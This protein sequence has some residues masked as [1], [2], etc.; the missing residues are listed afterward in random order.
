MRNQYGIISDYSF[1][2]FHQQHVSNWIQNK[3]KS[4][5]FGNVIPKRDHLQRMSQHSSTITVEIQKV[6]LFINVDLMFS[7]V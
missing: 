3:A 7:L 1:A 2:K 5:Y 6:Q 4:N